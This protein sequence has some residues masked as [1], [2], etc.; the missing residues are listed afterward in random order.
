MSTMLPKSPF[1]PSN[2]VA[3]SIM[4]MTIADSADW[5]FGCWSSSL[6]L[7]LLLLLL[8]LMCKTGGALLS[9]F[10]ALAQ[11]HTHTQ[12]GDRKRERR[13]QGNT[14]TT[15][16]RGRERETEGADRGD[17]FAHFPGRAGF[18]VYLLLAPPAA[19]L[20]FGVVVFTATQIRHY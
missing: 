15:R 12:P 18:C 19:F 3:S 1:V 10:R 4:A 13:L 9:F 16:E 2:F 8:L 11:T 6:L 14:H 7:F 17:F 20:C 5:C